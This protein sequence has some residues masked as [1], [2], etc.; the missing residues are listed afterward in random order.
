MEMGCIMEKNDWYATVRYAVL[1]SV[2]LSVYV[3]M[4]EDGGGR[5]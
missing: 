5:I 2:V 3:L 1:G 4:L